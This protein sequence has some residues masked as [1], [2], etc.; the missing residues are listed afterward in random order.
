MRA[1]Y[2]M[3]GV[4]DV[5][6]LRESLERGA[7]WTKDA[8]KRTWGWNERR[9]RAA[10]AELRQHGYPV[11]SSSEEGSVYRKARSRAEVEEF[12]ER[13]LVSRTRKL[14]EQI[15]EMRRA[16]DKHFGSDQLKIAI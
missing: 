5:T 1:E 8:A 11:I 10:V 4:D 12:I 9:F 15:R 13:E 14:E 7:Q 6:K 16:A 3:A 2:L